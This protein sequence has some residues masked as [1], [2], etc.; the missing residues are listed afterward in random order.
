M[1]INHPLNFTT[2]QDIRGMAAI[3]LTALRLKAGF[4]WMHAIDVL[5]QLDTE[6]YKREDNH[7]QISREDGSSTSF[8]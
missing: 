5:C 7:K 1:V 8:S 3:M 6:I 2:L 4:C